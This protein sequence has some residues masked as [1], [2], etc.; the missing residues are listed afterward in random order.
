MADFPTPE[1]RFRFFVSYGETDCMRVAYYGEYFHWF[2][3]ARSQFIRE[4][5]MSY[6]EVEERGVL[7]PVRQASC[8]YIRPLRYDDPAEIR[9]GIGQWGRASMTFVY[10]V[11]GPADEQGRTLIATGSTEHACINASGRPV[12]VPPWLRELFGA[13]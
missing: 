11:L 3:Q 12:G 8:R 1:A 2:E 13:P 7:L 4:R 6:R 10:E 9:C 5:G